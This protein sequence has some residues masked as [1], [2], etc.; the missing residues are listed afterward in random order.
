MMKDL[1]EYGD[2]ADEE[3]RRAAY[4]KHIRRL[5]EKLAEAEASSS[6]RRDSHRMD[7]DDDRRERRRTRS[8]ERSRDRRPERSER[9]DRRYS[10]ERDERA[11]KVSL[12]IRLVTWLIFSGLVVHRMWRSMMMWKRERYECV[13]AC[14][15]IV[16]IV[17]Y[18][19][20]TIFTQFDP[21]PGSYAESRPVADLVMTRARHYLNQTHSEQC[22]LISSRSRSRSA[23]L[24]RSGACP[25]RAL[26]PGH[27]QTVRRQENQL[28]SS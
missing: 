21:L 8:R 6:S 2:V 18:I 13:V 11:R 27:C 26:P 7:V 4:D 10:P 5:K 1:P 23:L 15:A 3:D 28:A 16:I 19:M 22:T 25:I 12:S 24:R 14:M 17:S 20:S 9:K